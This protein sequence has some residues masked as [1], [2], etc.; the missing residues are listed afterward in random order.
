MLIVSALAAKYRGL[1]LFNESNGDE[2]KLFGQTFLC[3]L[4]VCT[5]FKK[6]TK[7]YRVVVLEI[8]LLLSFGPTR[9]N[10]KL[11]RKLIAKDNTHGGVRLINFL[12]VSGKYYFLLL[13]IFYF[14]LFFLSEFYAST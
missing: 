11:I 13:V 9:V 5:I 12:G 3:T 6:T 1:K 7:P 14:I 8:I 10:V 4:R 2:S